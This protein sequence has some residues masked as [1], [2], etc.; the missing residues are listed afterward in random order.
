MKKKTIILIIIIILIILFII[1]GVLFYKYYNEK[2]QNSI[3]PSINNNKK[4]N[5]IQNDE[6]DLIDNST[7]EQSVEM[8]NTMEN[9]KLVKN[10]DTNNSNSVSSNSNKNNETTKPKYSCPKG[11]SLDGTMCIEKKKAI[12]TYKCVNGK[13]EGDRC[14]INTSIPANEFYSCSSGKL[15]GDTCKISQIVSTYDESEHSGYS[16]IKR[17]QFYNQFVENCLTGTNSKGTIEYENGI[18]Y[19]VLTTTTPASI[20]YDCNSKEGTLD[21]DKCIS[22]KT[23]EA[24]AEYSCEKG[25]SLQIPYCIKSTPAAKN[26]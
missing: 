9:H 4:Q 14:I 8:E 23:E 13:V 10:V 18:Y 2:N 22:I 15:N 20:S 17:R 6:N 26:N 5:L 7:V 1:S 12:V 21:G 3:K 19:C 24:Y 11:S 25:E 16:I